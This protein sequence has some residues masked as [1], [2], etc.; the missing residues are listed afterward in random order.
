MRSAERT[1]CMSASESSRHS[2]LRAHEA[3]AAQ[4][5]QT[6]LDDDDWGLPRLFDGRLELQKPPL[7]YWVVATPGDIHPSWPVDAVFY[8]IMAAGVAVLAYAALQRP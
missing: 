4:D 2:C 3:R 8:G 6:I 7:Y 5:A 1:T